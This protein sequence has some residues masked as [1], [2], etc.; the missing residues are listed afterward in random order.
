MRDAALS[1]P[2]YVGVP[3]DGMTSLLGGAC[4]RQLC[5]HSTLLLTARCLPWFDR[6]SLAAVG[7]YRWKALRSVS[8]ASCR[9]IDCISLTPGVPGV[10]KIPAMLCGSAPTLPPRLPVPP[11]R[12]LPRPRDGRG[13]AALREGCLGGMLV[14]NCDCVRDGQ[15]LAGSM[16]WKGIGLSLARFAD[17]V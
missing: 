16:K 1:L 17:L 10:D 2:R 6:S 9:E 15:R 11:P 3:G 8:S 7:P 4:D 12:P 14:L 13:N 5:L